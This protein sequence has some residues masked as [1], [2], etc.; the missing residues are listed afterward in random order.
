[1]YLPQIMH[2]PT[3]NKQTFPLLYNGIL[4]GIYIIEG[5]RFRQ[6]VKLCWPLRAPLIRNFV[7]R[8]HGN[9]WPS[10]P[11]HFKN[12][13]QSACRRDHF[14]DNLGPIPVRWGRS[15]CNMWICLKLSNPTLIVTLVSEACWDSGCSLVCRI[16][17]RFKL[18]WLK[19]SDSL[20]LSGAENPK[21]LALQKR[22]DHRRP[23]SSS[24]QQ[25]Y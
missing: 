11:P 9:T 21:R 4:M 13:A 10:V 6:N 2:L 8:V 5:T 15:L 22:F 1:M 16:H 3:P 23:C 24:N 25:A 7:F 19:T 18:S 20:L 12:C 17:S 14:W